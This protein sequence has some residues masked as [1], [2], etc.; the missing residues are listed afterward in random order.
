MINYAKPLPGPTAEQKPFWSYCRAHELRMQKCSKCGQIRFPV[1]IIC[2]KCQA[3]DTFEWVKL[4][5]KGSVYSYTIVNYTYHKAFAGEIPYVIAV[6]ALDE[7]PRLLSNIVKWKKED[8]KIGMPVE[9]E[10]E[11]VTEEFTLPKFKPL[12]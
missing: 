11:D 3:L 6:I 2:P 7:G 4:S 5:G 1:S 9:V 8:L 10:F 12:V